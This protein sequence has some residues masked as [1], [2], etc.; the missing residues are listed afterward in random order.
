M[1]RLSVILSAFLAASAAS[2]AARAVVPAQQVSSDWCADENW[3]RDREG[4]CEVREFTL[5]ATGA[6][7]NV[8]ASPNGGIRVEGAPRQDILV[9]AKVVAT[10]D[11]EARAREIAASVR[12][13]PTAERIEAEGVGSLRDREGWHVSYRLAVPSEAGLSLR[14]TNGG[15]TLNNVSGRI[16]FRTTN[17]GVKLSNLGGEVKGRTTNGGIDVDLTG[18]TWQGAGL[19][20]ET[21]NGGVKLAIPANYSAQL[22][23]GTVNGR[24]DVQFPV[25]VHGRLDRDISATLGSGGPTIRVRTS[26]G[27]VRITRKE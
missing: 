3:G 15:I 14:T 12:I 13:N 10:A 19:D 20:V 26:N 17:G 4:H 1:T 11:T 16:E 6:I 21:S 18:A 23:T 22:E 5:P 25:T 8:D 24:L 7:L 2:V 9:Q 27:G